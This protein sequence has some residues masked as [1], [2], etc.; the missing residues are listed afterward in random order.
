[1]DRKLLPYERALCETLKIG[2]TDY[3][4]FL[5]AQRDHSISEEERL[6]ELR[7]EPV[8]IVLAVV[9]VI[10][11]V[12]GALLAP[13]PPQQRRNQ[14]GRRQETFSPRFGFNNVQELAKY[15][16]PVN[17]IYCN[18]NQNPLGALRVGTS[19]LWSSVE[20]LGTT[21]FVQMLLLVGGGK[22]RDL[23]FNRT[24]IGQLRVQQFSG[25]VW[26]YYNEQG[27]P[28]RFKGSRVVGEKND[29]AREGASGEDIVHRIKDGSTWREGYSQVFTPTS[30]TT[31]GVYAP[32]P[33]N[34]EIMER[35]G[36]GEP[37]WRPLEIT[38]TGGS[39][40]LTNGRWRKGDR[41]TVRFAQVDRKVQGLARE[42][43]KDLRSQL[44]TNLDR[45]STYQL[46]SAEF[47]INS[48]T[49]NLNLQKNAI[50]AELQCIRPGRG[51]STG[52]DRQRAKTGL[53]DAKRQ[54]VQDAED[55][56][57]GPA[58]EA[59]SEIDEARI[60]AVTGAP[61][62][63][64]IDRQSEFGL[65]SEQRNANGRLSSIQTGAVYIDAFGFRYTFDGTQA[66][67][68]I[69]DLDENKSV[70]ID[71][72]GSIRKSKRDLEQFLAN[73]PKI[74][75]KRLRREYRSDLAKARQLKDDV[76]AG[77]YDKKFRQDSRALNATIRAV[78][79]EIDQR[80]DQRRNAEKAFEGNNDRIRDLER[81][82]DDITDEI[83]QERSKNT[84]D[85]DKISRLKDRRKNKRQETRDLK[86]GR[87]TGDDGTKRFADFR[88][89]DLK[90]LK[91]DL[92]DD[93]I[94]VRKKGYVR[95]VRSVTTAF[96]GLDGNRYA[97]GIRCLEDRIDNLDGEKVTDQ[98]GVNAV[99]SAYRTL[100]REKQQALRDARYLN[101]NWD[102]LERDLDDS[103]Y[104]KCL[105]KT[106]SIAYETVTAC[107]Y[108]KLNLRVRAFRR[109]SGR[110]KRYGKKDAPDGFKNSDNGLKSRMVFFTVRYRNVDE[111]SWSVVPTIF[112][113]Q[114][115][116]DQD[117]FVGIKF[118]SSERE[119]R[120][121]RIEPVLD[122]PAEIKEN[123]QTSYTFLRN[124]GG[125]TSI[126]VP[127]GRFQVV[128]G[129]EGVAANGFPD[130]AEQGP[131]YTNDWDLFSTRSDSQLQGSFEQ[132]P[133]VTLMTVTEQQRCSVAGKYDGMSLL[134]VH[135]FSSEAMQDLRSVSAY[136]T[137]GKESWVVNESN[138]AL[139]LS[140]ASTSYAPDIF[141]DT[142]LDKEN[143]IGSFAARNG[144]DWQ[145]LALTKRFCRNNGLGTQ[146]FMDGVLA[147]ASS[148]R[149]FW[150]EAA[151]YSLL[152][153]A[154]VGGKETLIPAIPVSSD[155]R[156]TTAITISAIFN[157]GN[158][159]PDS[160]K[161][162]FLDYG[163]NTKDLVATAIYRDTRP[164]DIMPRNSTVT[165]AL[166]DTDV[167]EA[168]WQTFDL[169]EWVSNRLQAVLYLRL[170]CQQR[171]HVKR[172]IEFRTIPSSSVIA[173]GSYVVVDIGTTTWDQITTGVI[174]EGGRLNLPLR[175]RILDGS[176][177]ALTYS[178]GRRPESFTGVTVSNGVAPALAGRLG[179]LVVLGNVSSTKRVFRVESVQMDREGEV[180]VT[181]S[182][183]PV[184]G[185]G[186]N[187]QSRVANLSAGLFKEIGVDC[188]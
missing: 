31:C 113:V 45:G 104:V 151:P 175:T 136:V 13:K 78:K 174:E 10:F 184:T 68:W 83:D 6:R 119:K 2:E 61:I 85:Q 172:R 53:S 134:A 164:N 40:G 178:S 33:I 29:P 71:R 72:R 17:L 73:K 106:S 103:F 65:D 124:S 54:S 81:E 59:S 98:V 155:G 37:R 60:S 75:T 156:A 133:E 63:L 114:R 153:F 74:S 166:A 12:A 41:I 128:G 56:L 102:T 8:S 94:G 95:F 34:V 140:A 173:P 5:A 16:D 158:I 20:S 126:T 87:D 177:N 76:L 11:N 19:L 163:D 115:S 183:H 77:E 58:E 25:N 186:N 157:Q 32:I 64:V 52:Y 138:G 55:I 79:A 27:G 26:V 170:L 42:A 125:R 185:S 51:P 132:G 146:L 47:R 84:P 105:C 57:E 116:A 36:K 165:V 169:S 4:E 135:A 182:E 90:E 46:G 180:T 150:I 120:E 92:E 88:L 48:I 176:Y 149:Q 159:L 108:V 129:R 147:E 28:V 99:R 111:E 30:M 97:C 62:Q 162:E 110:Q 44:V 50:T 21:Q 3:L 14:P 89:R 86:R 39:W 18:T 187:L 130:L 118:E 38:L 49:D 107:N 7:G 131:I 141:A 109:I 43:A 179:H 117:N 154:R 181:A 142:I 122:P 100:I 9:G 123:G 161:E 168:V 127:G 145:A 24:A 15:G 112:T 1:M 35:S 93:D 167:S 101:K 80:L 82:I 67:R 171:R 23:A 160:Y 139:S 144:V 70:T 66:V 96:I 137:Q 69:N 152:E 121:F 188:P 143:G 148:W 22:V 91:K